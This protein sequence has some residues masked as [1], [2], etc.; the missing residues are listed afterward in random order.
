V[1]AFPQESESG[2]SGNEIGRKENK[3]VIL[4]TE[5][6]IDEASDEGDEEPSPEGEVEIA[7]GAAEVEGEPDHYGAG[8]DGDTGG[9]TS[10]AYEEAEYQQQAAAGRDPD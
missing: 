1:L 6:P 7:D 2:D 10:T 3:V 5:A 4:E 9:V 8:R